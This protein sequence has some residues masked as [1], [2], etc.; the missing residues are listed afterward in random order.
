[1][2]SSWILPLNHIGVIDSFIVWNYRWN[3]CKYIKFLLLAKMEQQGQNLPCHL[4]Q[5]ENQTKYKKQWY[6]R[7]WSSGSEGIWTLRGRKKTRWALEFS[8]F[9]VW[10][11]FP[12]H[13]TVRGKPGRGC[14][15]TEM[16]RVH[17]AE[18]QKGDRPPK[19]CRGS[20]SRSSGEFWSMHDCVEITWIQR[21][22]HQKGL[23]G[24]IP[25]DHIGLGSHQP[26]WKSSQRKKTC[27]I[28]WN[29]KIRTTAYF[30]LETMQNRRQCSG[31][32]FCNLETACSF[33][34]LFLIFRR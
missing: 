8:Q 20:P 27:Y 17:R 21:K 25:R 11:K 30:S 9:T 10:R 28:K 23:E 29:K 18:N 19:I 7:Y 12:R 31:M 24:R 22:S 14:W 2:Y 32:Q 26:K 15:E 33:W 13:S 16:T 34:V 4:K 6:L 3:K 5:L 1:M